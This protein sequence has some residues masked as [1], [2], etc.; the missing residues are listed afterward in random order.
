VSVKNRPD[1]TVRT[2]TE[3]IDPEETDMS[4][5]VLAGLLYPREMNELT[6]TVKTDSPQRKGRAYVIP[7]EVV[8]PVE[9]MTFV[10]AADGKHKARVSVHYATSR[11]EKEFVSYGR[12]EQ[13][14]E[15]SD[16]QYKELHKIRYRYQSEVTVPK[17]KIRIAVGVTDSTSKLSSLQT[18]I[19]NTR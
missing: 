4:S 6:M 13:I 2:R 19:V 14:V 1:L 7:L 12:Q 15:L 8:I 3:V 5:R 10:R 16:R 17:G 9:K 18:L 11:D